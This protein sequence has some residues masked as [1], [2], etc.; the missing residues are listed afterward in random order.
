MAWWLT[1]REPWTA[2]A[3]DLAGAH[4]EEAARNRKKPVRAMGAKPVMAEQLCVT[5][6]NRRVAFSTLGRGLLKNV[7]LRYQ[8]IE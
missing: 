3:G 4:R 6:R 1:A 2:A 8:F 7:K 5:G